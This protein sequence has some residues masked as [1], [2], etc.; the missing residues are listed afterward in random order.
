MPKSSSAAAPRAPR[1]YGKGRVVDL[2]ALNDVRQALGEASRQR[3]LLI[4]HLHAIQDRF[5]HL[6]A[7]HIV[8]LAH[9]MRLATTE[10]Y[11]VATFYHH[12]DVV[13]EG[14]TAPPPPQTPWSPSATKDP[15][16]PS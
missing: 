7:A 3:D 8:A 12:F 11:E 10:V 14:E 16:P 2:K 1:P 4:E 5:G 9:E 13:R 6:S 15:S